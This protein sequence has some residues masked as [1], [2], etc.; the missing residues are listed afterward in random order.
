MITGE[1]GLEEEPTKG[2]AYCARN[3]VPPAPG[4]VR[5]QAALMDGEA[6][7]GERGCTVGELI[8]VTLNTLTPTHGKTG[9]TGGCLPHLTNQRSLASWGDDPKGVENR[10]EVSDF[11]ENSEVSEKPLICGPRHDAEAEEHPQPPCPSPQPQPLA[12]LEDR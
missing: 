9:P 4:C 3:Q 7:S 2:S 11:S 1:A 12:V 6:G 5:G 10:A 8:S